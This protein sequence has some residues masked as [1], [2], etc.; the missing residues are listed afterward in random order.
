M[1]NARKLDI[2]RLIAFIAICEEGSI[3]AA[4]RRLGIA[5]P[6]LTVTVSRLEDVLGT[7][8]LTRGIRGVKPT[9]AGQRLLRRAYEIVNLVES[10]FQELQQCT[11]DPGGDVSLGLP[12]SSAAVLALPLVERISMRYPKIRLRLVETFSGYLWNWLSEGQLDLAV[13]FDRTAT[14]EVQCEPIASEDMQ[15]VGRPGSLPDAS[16]VQART[17]DRYPLVMPS[18]LHAIRS[19]LEAHAARENVSL[20]VR[21]EIDAGQRLIRLV[22]TGRMFSV[23]AKSAVTQEI[24]QGTLAACMIAPP[25]TR[26]VC[27]GQRRA[28]MADPAVRAVITELVAE[29]Q[30]LIDTGIWKGASAEQPRMHEHAVG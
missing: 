16:T 2:P 21:V 14:P 26:A 7:V 12:S 15:L 25:I 1:Q 13:V 27:L 29:T 19:T 3:T 5:Q 8:L 11:V 6:A 10:T 23:L 17:L 4:A 9:E 24:Q 20:D 28:R 22:E 18:R 30:A